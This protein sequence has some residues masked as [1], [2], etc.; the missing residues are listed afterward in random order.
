VVGEAISEM[1]RRE[2]PGS[3][4]TYEP[5][6]LAGSLARL[7]DGDAEVAIADPVSIT[8]A[9]KGEP[10]F[11]RVYGKDDYGVVFRIVEGMGAYI[12]CRAEYCES[13]GVKSLTDVA[14]QKLPVRIATTV[15]SNIITAR[16]VEAILAG[17][18]I[19]EAGLNAWGGKLDYVPGS[20]YAQRF[21][22]GQVDMIISVGFPPQLASRDLRFAQ[23]TRAI[24][25][26]I[27]RRIVDHI[28][29][30]LGVETVVVPATA[31]EL[32][33]EDYYTT[34]VPIYLVARREVPPALTYKLAK[35]IYNHFDYLKSV[36][37]NFAQYRPSMLVKSGG[38]PLHP[39]A[40]RFFSEVG[41]LRA[42][43]GSAA[44]GEA[45][46]PSRHRGE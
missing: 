45:A 4:I 42:S 25:L 1:V 8:L 5:G 38:L 15:K 6:T 46:A 30:E 28:A 20:T 11:T 29:A 17:Y 24:M 32:L 35:A 19:S 41:L 3:A 10:P 39:G 26:P 12:L 33:D 18:G 9:G 14:Q 13:H 21:A 37:A 16:Q 27:A 44:A 31:Y 40:A 34:S 36:H 2:Y 7:L 22:D 43:K 23:N